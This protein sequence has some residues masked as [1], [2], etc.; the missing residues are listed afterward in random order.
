[1]RLSDKERAIQ[2][3]EMGEPRRFALQQQIAK[4]DEAG[5]REMLR[6]LTRALNSGEI[7]GRL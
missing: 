2:A 5:R 1:M 4:L 3:G 6:K 7:D